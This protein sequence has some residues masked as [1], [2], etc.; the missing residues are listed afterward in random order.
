VNNER[1]HRA[2]IK[3]YDRLVRLVLGKVRPFFGQTI[4]ETVIQRLFSGTK[5]LIDAARNTARDLAYKDYL[6]LIEGQDPVPRL[7]LHRFTDELWTASLEKHAPRGELVSVKVAEDVTLA[8]DYWTRD[9]EW[10]QRYDAAHR[11]PRTDRVARVDRN[12][13]SCPF[14]TLLNSRGAVYLSEESAA[15]TLHLGDECELILVLKGSDDYPGKDLNDQAKAAYIQAQEESGSG[16]PNEIMQKMRELGLATG[17]KGRVRKK[18][19]TQAKS[20]AARE[21][22]AVK[23]RLA[24]LEGIKPQADSAKKYVARELQRNREILKALEATPA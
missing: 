4:D 10:G 1:N 8:A 13:P 5:P 21:L 12:P 3:I 9:A 23:A 16:D 19:E 22:R 18:V 20:D 24:T 14:C 17:D 11:D 2:R 7:Q 15:R 6:E